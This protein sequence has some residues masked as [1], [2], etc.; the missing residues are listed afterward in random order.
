M[1]VCLVPVDDCSRRSATVVQACHD[2]VPIFLSQ[3]VP[4]SNAPSRPLM[5]RVTCSWCSGATRRFSR[6][7]VR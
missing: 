2:G 1:N 6:S 3:I 7:G 5:V 4:R